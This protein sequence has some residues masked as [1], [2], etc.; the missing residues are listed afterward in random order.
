MI[1][2]KFMLQPL[3]VAALALACGASQ[4]SFAPVIT[5][6]LAF[7]AVV[8]AKGTDTYTGFSVTGVTLSPI[9]RTTYTLSCD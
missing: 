3:A 2:K 4:A 6:Q 7:D 1:S 9:T 5:S 8:A